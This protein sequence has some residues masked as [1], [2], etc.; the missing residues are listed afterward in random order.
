MKLAI[1]N[2]NC[3]LR[4]SLAGMAALGLI[5]GV[6]LS[7]QLQQRAVTDATQQTQTDFSAAS[8]LEIKH[9]ATTRAIQWAAKNDGIAVAISLGTESKITPERIAEGLSEEF[10]DEG[11]NKFSFHFEQNDVGPTLVAFHYGKDGGVGQGPFFL[12]DARQG[13]RD[14][15]KQHRFYVEHPE[16]GF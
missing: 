4:L 10:W 11:L 13:A 16:F 9:Y 5:S 7:E 3:G 6:A 1:L 12:K 2:A 15:A 8:S 14:A